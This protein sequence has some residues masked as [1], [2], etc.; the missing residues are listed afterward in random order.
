VLIHV[1]VVAG[2]PVLRV[3]LT[4]Q[5]RK[6]LGLRTKDTTNKSSS[7]PSYA[8]GTIG[9]ISS[10]GQRRTNTDL[11]GDSVEDLIVDNNKGILV[12]SEFNT[13]VTDLGKTGHEPT[14]EVTSK[15]YPSWKVG[16]G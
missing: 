11:E 6:V 1:V 7:A 10:R 3:P 16:G 12:K 8:L 14:V 9:N 5:L 15:Q 2:L 4:R 13:R